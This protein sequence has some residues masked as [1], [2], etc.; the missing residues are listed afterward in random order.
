MKR[1][2]KHLSFLLLILF[3][4]CV[5]GIAPAQTIDGWYGDTSAFVYEDGVISIA[6]TAKGGSAMLYRGYPDLGEKVTFRLETLMDRLPTARNT[7]K[8]EVLSIKTE[9]QEAGIYVAPTLQGRGIGLFQELPSGTD[10]K[11]TMITLP[12]FLTDWERLT[13]CVDRDDKRFRLRAITPERK[14]L[15]SDWVDSLLD[16][17]VIRRMIFTAMFTKNAKSALRW[18][19]PTVT[20]DTYDPGQGEEVEVRILSIVPQ[21]S[22]KVTIRLDQS[23]DTS[24]AQAYCDGYAP[25]L[26]ALPGEDKGVEIDL[27][28]PFEE[29]SLYTI[30]IRGLRTTDGR[31]V[32]D[33]SFEVS[34][35]E[36]GQP[37][38][39]G[40]MYISEIMVSPPDRG[41]LEGF[42]YIELYNAH[43][44]PVSLDTLILQ[45]KNTSYALPDITISPRS[46][47]TLF[48]EESAPAKPIDHAVLL[49]K[50]P[51]LSGTFRLRLIGAKSGVVFD[52]VKFSHKLYGRGFEKGQAS[53]ERL[54]FSSEGDQWRRSSD[55]RGGSPSLPT[56]MKP[57][58]PVSPDAVVINELLLSP[59]TTGEKYIELH[60]PGDKPIALHDLYLSYRNKPDGDPMEWRLVTSESFIAAHGYIVLTP[61]PETLL[62]LYTDVPPGA[63]IERID[64]PALS[65]TYTEISLCAHADDEV[66]DKV[67]YRRQHLGPS[68]KDR[69]GAA[70]ERRQPTLDGT[71]PSSWRRALKES[72]GGTPGRPNSVYGL[73]PV[74]D[75]EDNETEWPESPTLDYPRM[76]RYTVHYADRLSLKVYT[77]SG[78]ALVSRRGEGCL[79]FIEDFRQ[80]NL[81]LDTALYI[82][83]IRI[84]GSEGQHDLYY[85]GKWLYHG[86]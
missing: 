21:L 44:H 32:S 10:R 54:S 61:Y 28:Q 85:K 78:E 36:G 9:G 57:A 19:L 2:Q 34:T 25:T 47:C 6:E 65:P 38:A 74:S 75:E 8:W 30:H 77:L 18:R 76:L 27:H 12:A 62:R 82:I 80:G 5:R 59:P 13:I 64:F 15:K 71:K 48:G 70:L 31:L 35:G 11:L 4:L 24:G 26:R 51:A 3:C 56:T 39:E 68:S 81:P 45:Y 72:N 33:L 50:F 22:G 73:P 42:K 1:T 79:H 46:Y 84:K 37:P 67:I 52:R 23:V 14:T 40:G 69:T 49:P 60:N 53:V 29:Q 58:R 43:D 41:P 63:L 55:P 20:K 17:E 66:I 16:G 83:S 86:L 7:F